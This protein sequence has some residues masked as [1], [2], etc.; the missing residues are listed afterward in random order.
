MYIRRLCGVYCSTRH[1]SNIRWAWFHVHSSSWLG[2]LRRKE[3]KK[4]KHGEKAFNGTKVSGKLILVKLTHVLFKDGKLSCAYDR[5]SPVWVLKVWS[6]SGDSCEYGNLCQ[7]VGRRTRH[8]NGYVGGPKFRRW[9]EMR[10]V[11]LVCAEN[12]MFNFNLFCRVVECISL[13]I[14]WCAIVAL[15]D[16][17]AIS[18]LDIV[19]SHPIDLIDLSCAVLLMIVGEL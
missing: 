3:R 10:P 12:M 1:S 14:H 8:I 2:F 18:L 9:G 5:F 11:F 15:S 16:A 17:C 6:H 7:S 19:S 4:K 13:C